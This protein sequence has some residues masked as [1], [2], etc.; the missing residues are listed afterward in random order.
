[1]EPQRAPATRAGKLP[2]VV[3]ETPIRDQKTRAR[4]ARIAEAALELFAGRGYAETTIDQIAAAAGVGRR[5]VFRH[6]PT[7]EAILFDHLV[8]RREVAVQLLRERPPDEPPL[9]SLH[10]VLRALCAEGY[11]RRAL[12]H[13]RAV[14]TTNPQ[15][16]EEE[17]TGGFRA[18]A[19]NLVAALQSRSGEE[20]SLLELYG[21][22][23]IALSWL[24]TACGI[25]LK[26]ARPSLVEC[27]DEIVAVCVRSV[28]DDLAPSVGGDAEP[29]R[30]GRPTRAIS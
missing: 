8:V 20:R 18:F 17:L 7:K 12:A 21:V 10:A 16:A 4:R 22:T 6:F 1:V 11:D 2:L 19:T 24:E 28:A 15:V 5:T 9:V 23:V 26:E 3:A 14:L 29:R 13:I 25:Y 27:F 30:R